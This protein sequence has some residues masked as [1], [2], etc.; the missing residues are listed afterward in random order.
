M[1]S[2]ILCVAA[3]SQYFGIS[4]FFQFPASIWSM[5][6][7]TSSIDNRLNNIELTTSSLQVE[8]DGLSLF[9][10]SYATTGSNTFNGAQIITGSVSGNIVS[11]SIS[12]NT[13]SFDFSLGNFFELTLPATET[14]FESTNIQSGQ[15]VSIKITNATTSSAAIFDNTFKFGGQIPYT[16]TQIVNAIDVITFVSY[17][18]ATSTKNLFTWFI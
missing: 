13:A 3:P 14:R 2:K 17:E 1:A 4:P 7:E 9:T 15:T 12:A 6:A 8:V 18:L 16:P 5:W 11:Q 10:G